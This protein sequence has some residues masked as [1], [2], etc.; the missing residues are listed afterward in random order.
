[1]II[2]MNTIEGKYT[3]ACYMQPILYQLNEN[4]IHFKVSQRYS[5]ITFTKKVPH[6]QFIQSLT[7]R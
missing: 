3:I 6:S 5:H 2:L 1:M 7:H 4:Y